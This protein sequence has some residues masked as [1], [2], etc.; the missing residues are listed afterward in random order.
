MS[1]EQI[2]RIFFIRRWWIIGCVI[3]G[4]FLG[5]A[6]AVTLPQVYDARSQVIVSVSENSDVSAAESAVYIDDRMP[7]VLEI[8]RSNDF[9][10]EVARGSG[11]ERTAAEIRSELEATVVPDTTVI[12]IHARDHNAQQA[13]VLA[14]RAADTMSRSFVTD[15]LGPDA[16]MDV[17]VLQKAETDDAVNFPDPIRFLGIGAL[18]GLLLGLVVAPIRH[19]LDS[20]IRDFSDILAIS[21]A[22]LLAVRMQRPGGAVRRQI[23]SAGAATSTGGLLARL[24]VSSQSDHPVT[25]TLCGVGGAGNE[26]AADL[27]ETAAASGLIC[28]LVS[29]DP[30]ALNTTHYR[31]LSQV[32]GVSVIDVSSE[33][34]TGVFSGQA[35]RTALASQQEQYDLVVCLSSDF[36][37]HPQT[38]GFLES[39]G[40]A[41]IVTTLH[42]DRADLRATRELL[43]A[44]DTTAAGVV[45]VDPTTRS[46]DVPDFIRSL[47]ELVVDPHH[48]SKPFI[49]GSDEPTSPGAELATQEFDMVTTPAASDEF[50]TPRENGRK[51][52]N[53]DGAQS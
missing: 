24:G 6:L 37:S 47:D 16:N 26:L 30:T 4:A 22:G 43:R 36:A 44:N 18:A 40:L 46:N 15:Q 39:S 9:A 33:A 2:L 35:V 14:D 17:T 53:T 25:V 21:E 7:T 49:V 38:C 11:I 23:T 48:T 34:G 51:R 8:S 29:A 13:K 52:H 10:E 50:V 20:R 27:V 42:P 1:G 3:L 31:E 5:T 19:G 41:V 12:E 28:A 45:V 32:L